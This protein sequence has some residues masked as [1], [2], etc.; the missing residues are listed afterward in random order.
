MKKKNLWKIFAVSFG[1]CVVIMA[2]LLGVAYSI[3]ET[4]NPTPD[5]DINQ[6]NKVLANLLFAQ[7]LVRIACGL[8]ILG[9]ILILIAILCLTVIKEG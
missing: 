7:N 2:I 5:M 3:S 6:L 1:I 4:N 9:G 8:I